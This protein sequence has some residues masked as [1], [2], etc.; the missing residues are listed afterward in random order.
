MTTINT[1]IITLQQEKGYDAW[2]EGIEEG[3]MQSFE[4]FYPLWC[5]DNG[6][7]NDL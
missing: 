3:N 7:F 4:E 1:E 6:L 5:K 2:L